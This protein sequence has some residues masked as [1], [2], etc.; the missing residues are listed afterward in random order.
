MKKVVR[1]TESDLHNIIEESVKRIIL[2][3][4]EDESWLGDKFRQ[5]SRAAKSFMGQNNNGSNMANDGETQP[6]YNF[7]GRFNAA[8]T[9]WKEQGRMNDNN[10]N[11]EVLNNLV[12]K[13]GSNATIGQII[14]RLNMSNLGAQGRISKSA[15][16][17]YNAS[18]GL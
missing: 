1:L 4:N 15:G 9:G 8:K 7:R 5:G 6:T 12:K 2:E 17:I 3:N 14:K 13:F 11:M 18:A 10:T 16:N